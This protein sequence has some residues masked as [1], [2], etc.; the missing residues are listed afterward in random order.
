MPTPGNSPDKP[1]QSSGCY[2]SVPWSLPDTVKVIPGVSYAGMRI[3]RAADGAGGIP[4]FTIADDV[5]ANM[6]NT[7]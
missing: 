6:S 3:G 7:E 4:S 5:F 2:V 1:P